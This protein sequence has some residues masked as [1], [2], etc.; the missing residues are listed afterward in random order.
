L[1]IVANTSKTT[2]FPL[3]FNVQ[4]KLIITFTTAV[5]SVSP[6]NWEL[7]LPL[8]FKEALNIAAKVQAYPL[9]SYS[10]SSSVD[11]A[12]PALRNLDGLTF[13]V[14]RLGEPSILPEVC[15][16]NYLN[17]PHFSALISNEFAVK[18]FEES[19]AKSSETSEPPA[20]STKSVCVIWDTSQ[21]L[22]VPPSSLHLEFFSTLES[23]HQ[24]KNESLTFT[25]FY[26]STSLRLV[27]KDLSASS[28]RQELF[29]AEYDGGTNLAVLG[30]AFMAQVKGETAFDY[31]LLYTDGG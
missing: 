1:F 21:S 25:L 19:S 4:K 15:F 8:A 16:G 26:F 27:A 23:D 5:T 18:V 7:S 24:A 28:L 20:P 12:L 9:G 3:E 2:I 29:K 10:V 17:K 11:L 13:A 14:T 6:S 31:F 22:K 30:E